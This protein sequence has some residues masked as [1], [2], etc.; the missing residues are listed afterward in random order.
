M[1]EGMDVFKKDVFELEG[2]PAFREYY[3]LFIFVWQAIY[4]G[5]YKAWHEVPLK[6]IRD[7]KGKTRTLATMN[8][9]KMACSQMA[10]YVWNE[11]CSI[12]ASMKSAPE[13]DPLDGFLQYVLKDNRFGSAFGDL[14]EKSFA[15]GGGAL[16][17][18]VEI[19]KDE[20]GN[21]LGE[22]KVR[23][24][25]T[26]AS[27]FVPTAWD[28]GKVT[29][30]I[31]VSREAR[32]GYY[33]TVVEWHHWDGTTYR[34]TN[35]LYRQPIK[36]SEPQNILGWWY[37]L[38]KVYP[39][40]SPD[41]TIEDVHQAFFQYVRPFGA[42]YADDNSPLGMS[43][44][45]PALN[46]L[47]GLDI[48]FDSLQREF[49]L[50]KK[51][52]IAPARSMKVSAGVN[53]SRPDRYFDADD[54]VWEAL[55]TDNPEDLKIYDNSVDLR[56]EPHITG[57]N[58]D[59]SILCA[60]IGFDPGTL[61]F[62]ATKGLKTATEVISENSKTFGTVKAHENLLKDALVDMVHAIFDLAVRYGL[63]W[64]GKTIESLISGGYD[65]SVQFDDSIIE[66]KNAEINR[67]VS[68]V[69]AGLLS[70]KKFMT[71]MLGYTPE[72]ADSELKQI[73]EEQR[74]NS[75]VVDRI[76]GGME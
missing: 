36:G 20:N 69:G 56:V 72:D 22:G 68:L 67:G 49:V 17:E 21:D 42:N 9:G 71:D 35:D 65:V 15:L 4:K 45:A 70:K 75:V 51:R 43:I 26:M 37:P 50:G 53:G 19:P 28:N 25:Y 23:I 13:D 52:I 18:W 55:A 7:P 64:E 47:H 62:D 73:S 8:A 59:L 39:L 48:M 5:F 30:G 1:A 6:T 38:D 3:T 11:R 32:D 74:T 34:I 66:D 10:R 54:E 60:Q 57:I 41:T 16:K 12:T 14:L 33:Y 2:V 40:L 61:S 24:G 44:Y 27:Q 31:F 58:G 63:T 29:S 46:T 76:F